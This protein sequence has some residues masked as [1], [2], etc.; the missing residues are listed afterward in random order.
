LNVVWRNISHDVLNLVECLLL[1]HGATCAEIKRDGIE[2]KKTEGTLNSLSSGA[3]GKEKTLAT[4]PRS[5]EGQRLLA[6]LTNG[7]DLRGWCWRRCAGI[8][9]QAAKSFLLGPANDL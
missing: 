6:Q 9:N 7:I 1:N 4:P 8:L 5:R 3:C 2:V